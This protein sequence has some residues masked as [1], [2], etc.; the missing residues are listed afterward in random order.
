MNDIFKKAFN[1]NYRHVFQRLY[2]TFCTLSVIVIFLLNCLLCH[3]RE[4]H[5]EAN[6][7][8]FS[9]SGDFKSAKLNQ[10]EHFFGTELNGSVAQLRSFGVRKSTEFFE[11]P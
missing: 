3:L 7:E 4:I 2:A 11:T 6:E 1:Y 5:N 9:R 10:T 8:I